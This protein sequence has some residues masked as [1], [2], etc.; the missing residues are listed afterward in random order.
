[1]QYSFTKKF[2]GTFTMSWLGNPIST[3]EVSTQIR[4]IKTFSISPINSISSITKFYDIV[5][6]ETDKHYFQKFFSYS[7]LRSG[8]SFSVPAP[9]T[10]IAQDYCPLDTLYLNL[11]YYRIDTDIT[12]IPQLNINTIVIEG[13]YDIEETSDIIVVPDNGYILT[14][15][16]I[17]KV[18]KLTGFETIGINTDN[19]TIRYRFTQDN[20]RTYTPWELLTTE[21]ISTIKLN[22]VRFAQVEYSIIKINNAITSKV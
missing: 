15:K 9:I 1:M 19:L 8:I 11:I 3:D 17:Y 10:G 22:P 20:G 7:N 14:P 16:D 2:D 21:N 5:K 6:G 4:D 12:T 13:T 18:F